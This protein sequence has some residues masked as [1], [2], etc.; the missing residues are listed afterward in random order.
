MM[1]FSAA[2]SA[3]V[4]RLMSP[5]VL[6]FAVPRRW[7]SRL[8]AS[9]AMSI[10]KLSINLDRICGIYKIHPANLANHVNSVHLT[11]KQRNFNVLFARG[12]FSL[13]ISGVDVSRDAETGIVRQHA[14]QSLR[15]F[16]SSIRNGHLTSMQRI[17]N[18]HTTT[19][20]KRN[21]TRAARRVEQSIQYGPIGHRVRSVL[22]SFS[23]A[24]RRRHRP[25]VEMIAPDR[26]RRFE[27]AT[28]HEIVDRLAHLS[29]FAVTEP[30]NSRRQSLEVHTLARQTQ[31]AIQ[32]AIVGK[33][34]EREI[35]SLAYVVRIAR[36]RRP[37][38]WS[39]AFTEKRTNVFRNESGYL[40]RV[41]ASR[42]KRLLANVVAVVECNRARTLQGQ[43]RLD[44]LGHR[45]GGLLDVCSRVVRTQLD[46]VL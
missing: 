1:R 36:Q 15:C 16:F 13:F 33:H 20:M 45:R 32:R 10:A 29:P 37:A 2:M 9:R 38:K 18:A 43:H 27:I 17:A 21:P 8:P 6:T 14:I 46:G 35:V 24:K 30:T 19:M 31:P 7:T 28:L 41:F 26:D 44:V 34:L 5:L 3:S 22:H 12:V 40:K 23:L 42:I 4:T 11:F 25:R 39:L